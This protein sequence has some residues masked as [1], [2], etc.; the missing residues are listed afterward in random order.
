MKKLYFL[1]FSVTLLVFSCSK[2][3][4]LDYGLGPDQYAIN[5]AFKASCPVIKVYPGDDLAAAFELAKTAGRRSVVKLMPGVFNIGWTEVHEFYGILTGSGQGV[6]IITNLPDLDPAELTSLH[7]LPALIAFIGGDVTVSNIS[8]QLTEMPWLGLNE[9]PNMSMLLFSDY[10]AD[11]MPAK[12][13]IS[14]N[15]NNLEVK[16]LQFEYTVYNVHGAKFSPDH[17]MTGDGVL[18]RSNIEANVNNCKFANLDYAVYAWGCKSGIFRFGTDGGNSFSG[19][20]RG[21][22]VN[23]NL[24]LNVKIW[25][26]EFD[27]PWFGDGIDLNTGEASIGPEFANPLEVSHA[28]AGFYHIKNNIINARDGSLAFG[29]YDGWRI[30]HPEN[31]TWMKMNWQDNSFVLTGGSGLGWTYCLKDALF[32]KNTISGDNSFL[33]N[34]FLYWRDAEGLP[35]NSSEGCKWLNNHFMSS[36]YF[37]LDINVNNYLIV[38]DLTNVYIDDWG[39]NNKIIGKTNLNHAKGI[40]NI[41]GMKENALRKYQK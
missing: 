28:D 11:F 26:N 36:L 25:N 35:N 1:L 3:S 9:S 8:V 13:N 37:F 34:T 29:L 7:K 10:S 33:I 15:L 24:G 30:V 32:S 17:V 41:D 19:N 6:S 14:V 39:E 31:P 22:V 12:K 40:L 4:P 2:E 16:G 20:S 5:D 23:E 21:I 27:V 18:P 38:G